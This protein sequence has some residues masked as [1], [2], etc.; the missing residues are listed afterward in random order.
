MNFHEM[1]RHI[2]LGVVH[3][4]ARTPHARNFVL[5]GGLLT[6]MWLPD[7]SM[8]PTRDLDFVGDFAFSI[9]DTRGRFLPALAEQLDDNVVIAPALRA[10]GIWLETEWPGVRLDLELGYGAIDQKLSIDIGSAIRSCRQR[11]NAMAFAWSGPSS[12]SRG[13]CTHSRRWA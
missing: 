1:R 11:S 3:R 10:T 7:P 4:L 13:S 9:D 2:T 12:R 5:R 8:R 6:S